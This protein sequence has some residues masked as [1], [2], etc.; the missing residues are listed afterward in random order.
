MGLLPYST[1][2]PS[3]SASDHYGTQRGHVGP[4][5]LEHFQSDHCLEE[6]E[7]QAYNSQYIIQSVLDQPLKTETINNEG[8]GWEVGC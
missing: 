8:G 7:G 5:T 4:D 1:V 2:T 6:R 3:Y